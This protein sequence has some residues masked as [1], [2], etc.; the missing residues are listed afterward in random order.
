[1][2]G[3]IDHLKCV[4]LGVQCADVNEPLLSPRRT[5]DT[6]IDPRYPARY[7]LDRLVNSLCNHVDKDL[8]CQ[9]PTRG[10]CSCWLSK[11]QCCSDYWTKIVLRK[12]KLTMS[13]KH[14][15]S[16][17]VHPTAALREIPGAIQLK[18]ELTTTVSI[19]SLS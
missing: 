5:R 15:T 16:N 13:P 8:R 7:H 19:A 4:S 11:S 6:R 12:I 17:R 2:F 18:N 10:P 1:M 3:R 9:Y 14:C